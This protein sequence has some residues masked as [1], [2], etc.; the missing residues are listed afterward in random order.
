MENE[1]DE[2]DLVVR[3]NACSNYGISGCRTD[4]QSTLRRLVRI[5]QPQ[6]DCLITVVQEVG[7][8]G[9]SSQ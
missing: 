4:A 1:I 7:Y 9:S 8:R 3:F 6:L 5:T 2:H